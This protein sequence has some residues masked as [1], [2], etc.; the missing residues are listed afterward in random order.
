MAAT[1]TTTVRSIVAAALADR[2][3]SRGLTNRQILAECHK[4]GHVVTIH[5]VRRITRE[6][7]NARRLRVAEVGKGRR[8]TYG[9]GR[10]A[11]RIVTANA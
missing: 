1:N 3:R 11:D 8:E 10:F 7:T 4:A 9:A 2:R 6:L 5:A